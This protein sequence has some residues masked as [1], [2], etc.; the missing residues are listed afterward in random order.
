MLAHIGCP[1]QARDAETRHQR[2]DDTATHADTMDAA[3]KPDQ[4]GRR[5]LGLHRLDYLGITRAPACLAQIFVEH[6]A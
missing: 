1:G 6:H 2:T 4:E 5:K 3:D